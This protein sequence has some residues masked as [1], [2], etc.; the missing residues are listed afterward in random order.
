MQPI[1]ATIAAIVVTI[2]RSDDS[3]V[4]SIQVIV[5]MTMHI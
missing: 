4:Y 5:A 1:A 2:G 3:T